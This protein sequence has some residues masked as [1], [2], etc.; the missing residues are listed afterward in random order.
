MLRISR[1]SVRMQKNK[2][3]NNSEYGHFL[4]SVN[5][6]NPSTM[7]CFCKKNSIL[8]RPSKKKCA[9]EIVSKP[10]GEVALFR[11]LVLSILS[12]YI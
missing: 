3:Q 2:D 6:K 11:L 10:L 7:R 8:P 12:F 4:R 5:Y 9:E 1:Y